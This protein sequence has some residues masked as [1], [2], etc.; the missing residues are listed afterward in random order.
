MKKCLMF[1]ICLLFVSAPAWAAIK[2]EKQAGKVAVKKTDGY[3]CGV[4]EMKYLGIYRIDDS[5]DSNDGNIYKA[6]FVKVT[7]E[8]HKALYSVVTDATERSCKIMTA[9]QIDLYSF[10]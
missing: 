1:V 5:V 3:A 2:C 10:D 7:C 9:K 4:E 8:S 6:Y